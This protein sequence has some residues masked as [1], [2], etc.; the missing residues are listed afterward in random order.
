MSGFNG[1]WLLRFESLLLGAWRSSAEYRLETRQLFPDFCQVARIAHRL[2][3]KTSE[4]P[5]DSSLISVG[6]IV[7][8]VLPIH[9]SLYQFI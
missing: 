1:T 7:L 8:L 3:L 6:A 9:P 4:A 2:V 5:L